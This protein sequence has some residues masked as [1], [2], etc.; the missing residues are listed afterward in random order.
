MEEGQGF[1]RFYVR[2]NP[3]FHKYLGDDM[4]VA[5]VDGFE[6]GPVRNV[7]EKSSFN[8][9]EA[10]GEIQEMIT[11]INKEA[12]QGDTNIVPWEDIA[13]YEFNV[14]PYPDWNTWSDI[15]FL[16]PSE[17]LLMV[18][19]SSTPKWVDGNYV[20]PPASYEAPGSMV[21]FISGSDFSNGQYR[22]CSLSKNGEVGHQVAGGCLL[23]IVQN[24]PSVGSIA[25]VQTS[26]I[27]R[28]E[29]GAKFDAGCKLSVGSDGRCRP[30][31]SGD[32]VFGTAL[33]GSQ[34]E[35]Q[36]A[37]VSLGYMGLFNTPVNVPNEGEV[38]VGTSIKLNSSPIGDRNPS[39]LKRL[40][41]RNETMLAMFV[42]Y[43]NRILPKLAG[44][45]DDVTVKAVHY[46]D[47]HQGF[48]LYLHSMEF[49]VVMPGWEIPMLVT[50][51]GLVTMELVKVEEFASKEYASPLPYADLHF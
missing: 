30:A 10:P 35:G 8:S 3:V 23:G 13:P 33:L 11:R 22:G 40:F 25:T 48:N 46:D 24:K 42:D 32:E 18:M 12:A 28:M 9:F 37:S 21:S 29:A 47:T 2:L 26:G 19:D 1:P 51:D 45:P 50:D 7:F 20:S 36:I 5:Y 6:I 31:V 41:V 43:T 39:R 44:L 17:S 4:T 14:T 34:G 27:S 15:E 49:E 38:S 16:P